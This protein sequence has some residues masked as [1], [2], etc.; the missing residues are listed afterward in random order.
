M[1]KRQSLKELA[2]IATPVQSQPVQPEQIPPSASATREAQTRI[3]SRQ[4]A[5]HF[6]AE[7][8]QALRLLAAEQDREQQE[9]L[10]EA[11]NMLFERYGKP[12]RAAVLG[13]RRK[14]IA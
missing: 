2:G 6:K 12:T 10:A 8:A 13:S 5:G 1:T 3:G 4:V 7:V 14:R 11:L 9:L